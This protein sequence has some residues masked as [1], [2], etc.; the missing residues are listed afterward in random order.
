MA[1]DFHARLRAVSEGARIVFWRE[2]PAPAEVFDGLAAAAREL[3]IDE[4]D[5]YGERGA[6]ARVESEVADLLGKPAAVLFPS[7]T[8]A[9]QCALRVWCDRT[10]S[11]RV[12]LPDLSHLLTHEADGPRR[13]HDFEFEHL[14]TGREVATAASLESVPGRLGALL[15]E[16]PLR[17]A[18][19]QLPTWEELTDLSAAARAR[20]V[21]LHVDGARIWESQPHWG[22]SLSELGELV[23]SIYVSLYKGLGAPHGALV[24][25]DADVAAELRVWR[26]RMGGTLFSMA[27][28]A[29]AGLR[30]LRDHLPRMASCREWARDLASALVEVGL[31][32]TPDPPHMGTFEVWAPGDADEI[33]ERLLAW[34]ADRR[35]VPS[36]G[37]RPAGV[38]GWSVC[39]LACYDAALA[40]DPVEVAGWIAEVVGP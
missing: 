18:G 30:G 37:W 2:R 38:P 26:Q 40:H 35:I 15:V 28:P 17:D 4:A 6:V 24:A 1:E 10:G 16:L 21:P 39:E 9:Q 7:G 14:T 27:V 36:G 8:M 33:N 5:V 31:R 32:V 12:A 20:G 13:L 11:R 25:C 22:K 34:I 29:V 3:D 19:C 23:D